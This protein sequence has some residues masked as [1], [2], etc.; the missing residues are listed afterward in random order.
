M[1]SSKQLTDPLAT[2]AASQVDAAANGAKFR[3]AAKTFGGNAASFFR[4]DRK[5]ESE[6]KRLAALKDEETALRAELVEA[7]RR[8]EMAATERAVDDVEARKEKCA[9]RLAQKWNSLMGEAN[10]LLKEMTAL[11]AEGEELHGKA[12]KLKCRARRRYSVEMLARKKLGGTGSFYIPLTSAVLPDL[13]Y[14]YGNMWDE[15][16][17]TP[18]TTY[19]GIIGA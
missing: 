2:N 3:A 12:A 5:A 16:A 7:L 19:S 14:G 18:S 6:E 1:R 11:D 15:A 10:A 8:E 4:A 9:Y 17:H 13:R